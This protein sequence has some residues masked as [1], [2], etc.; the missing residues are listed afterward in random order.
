MAI[1]VRQVRKVYR[2]GW[3]MWSSAL[4]GAVVFTGAAA[5]FSRQDY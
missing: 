1:Q 3:P 2:S 5:L 4:F